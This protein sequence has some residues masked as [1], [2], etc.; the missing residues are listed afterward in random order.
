[1]YLDTDSFF[2]H[3][4]TEDVYEDFLNPTL[5]CH[6]DM[7]DFNSEHKWFN[8]LNKKK[9]GCFKIKCVGVPIVEF[10]GL[11]PKPYTYRTMDA[12]YLENEKKFFLRKAKGISKPVVKNK[13][14]FDD[15]KNCLFHN[16]PV[17]TSMVVFRSKK[18]CIKTVKVNNLALYYEDNKRSICENSI[19]T[20]PYGH[21]SMKMF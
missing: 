4:F 20:L 21:Y 1:M 18:Y 10:I 14:T 19:D 9:L 13:I 3:V 16:Q 7:S 2:D 6:L 12:E 11:R 15:F 5:K 17:R 8:D